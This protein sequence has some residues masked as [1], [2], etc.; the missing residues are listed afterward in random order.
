MVEPFAE[1]NIGLEVYLELKRMKITWYP[2]AEISILEFSNGKKQNKK[3][4][5][6][7]TLATTTT[8]HMNNKS[9]LKK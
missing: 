2:L 1:I 6:L 4:S 9:N 3:D 5:S 8:I 7:E